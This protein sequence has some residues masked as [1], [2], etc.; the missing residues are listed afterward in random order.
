MAEDSFAERSAAEGA[1]MKRNHQ[2][3]TDFEGSGMKT[4]EKIVLM[5]P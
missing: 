3:A 2:L 5:R 1:G 4:A